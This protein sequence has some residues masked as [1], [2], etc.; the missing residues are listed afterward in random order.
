MTTRSYEQTVRC[1]K[2]QSFV[3]GVQHGDK[4]TAQCDR[5]KKTAKTE[6]RELNLKFLS[7]RTPTNHSRPERKLQTK[8]T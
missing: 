5:H 1:H 6:N 4:I 2:T 8:V 3:E 7:Q